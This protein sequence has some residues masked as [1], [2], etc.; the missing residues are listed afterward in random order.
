MDPHFRRAFNILT[1]LIDYAKRKD[2]K[3]FNIDVDIDGRETAWTNVH[4]YAVALNDGL[5][6]WRTYMRGEIKA[7]GSEAEYRRQRAES[8]AQ[9]FERYKVGVPCPSRLL[10]AC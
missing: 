2:E 4:T 3:D 10:S 5:K 1:R 9:N 6:A 7:T 8:R